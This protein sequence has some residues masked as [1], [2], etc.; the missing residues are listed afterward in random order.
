MSGF[1][2]GIRAGARV[3]QGQVIGYVGSTGLANGPHLCF[4]FWKNGQQ[5]D[6]LKVELPPSEPVAEAYQAAYEVIMDKIISDLNKI[7]YEAAEEETYA[8]SEQL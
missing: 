4:R 6:A 3:R 7:Q 8:T 5:V 2:S 1:A